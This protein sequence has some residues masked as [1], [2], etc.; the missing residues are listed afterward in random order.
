MKNTNDY[1]A[2]W[3]TAC[4]NPETGKICYGGAARNLR[5]AQAG[6]AQAINN[7][8]VVTAM[9]LLEP[10]VMRLE[11]QLELAKEQNKQLILILAQNKNMPKTK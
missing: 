2:G 11:N 9:Q 1:E 7:N 4:F 10:L 3:T 6:G 5:T 8:G